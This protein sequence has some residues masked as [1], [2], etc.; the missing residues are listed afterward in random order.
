MLGWQVDTLPSKMVYMADNFITIQNGMLGWQVDK[1][2]IQ[3]G[4]LV[5]KICPCKIKRSS[6][7]NRWAAG[8]SVRKK[9]RKKDRRKER[10]KE[11]KNKE[12]QT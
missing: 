7:G 3:N 2:T 10:R 4:C 11:R 1:S 9:E 6:N 5:D 8:Q 12:A